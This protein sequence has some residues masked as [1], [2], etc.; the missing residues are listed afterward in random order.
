MHIPGY[1]WCGPGTNTEKRLARN[2]PGCK[3]FR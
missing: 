3:R 1:N 2:D